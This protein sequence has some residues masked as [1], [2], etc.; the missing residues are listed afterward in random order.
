[1]AQVYTSPDMNDAVLGLVRNLVT[2]AIG[3][4]LYYSLN[5]EETLVSMFTHDD[6]AL[7]GVFGHNYQRLRRV[8]DGEGNLRIYCMI[9]SCFMNAY[10]GCNVGWWVLM[11]YSLQDPA[12]LNTISAANI[13][14]PS[15]QR[16]IARIERLMG[17]SIQEI[18]RLC[19]GDNPMSSA[20]P[21]FDRPNGGG[22]PK[23]LNMCNL[24]FLRE[25]MAARTSRELVPDVRTKIKAGHMFKNVRDIHP[26]LSPV[27]MEFLD[28]TFWSKGGDPSV[29]PWAI[30]AH[31]YL[32]NSNNP[33]IQLETAEGGT[34]IAGPS[35][36]TQENLELAELFNGYEA[37][38]KL[39]YRLLSAIMVYLTDAPHHSADEV[40]I[41]TSVPWNHRSTADELLQEDIRRA[42]FCCHQTM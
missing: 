20:C 17:H 2:L 30:A 29:V 39:Y 10:D 13:S 8:L 12:V 38:S 5:I 25:E 32:P 33:F 3:Y 23:V 7:G 34:F 19:P 14:I 41:S 35:G 21:E 1:M 24:F 18:A 42:R 11:G 9:L 15:I 6:Q 22:H 37:G 36:T 4:S 26:P 31:M 16:R 28:D 40:M 27:E